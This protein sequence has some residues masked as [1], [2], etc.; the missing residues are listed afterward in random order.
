MEKNRVI[1]VILASIAAMLV[2]M[3][4]KSCTEDISKT[5]GKKSTKVPVAP[6]Y[7]AVYPTEKKS[8]KNSSVAVPDDEDVPQED[9]VEYIPV[10]EIF[11]DENG[12]TVIAVVSEDVP[13]PTTEPKSVLEE[14]QEAKEKNNNNKL[15]GYNHG[16]KNETP[17]NPYENATFPS[18]FQIILN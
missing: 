2:I 10:T 4:G 12:E 5:N 3:T 16:K 11:T 18:D 6:Q 1:A 8:S 17:E 15:S 14:Y 7:E 13:E 9:T